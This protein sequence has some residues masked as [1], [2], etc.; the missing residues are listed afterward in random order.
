[1]SNS[2][3]LSARGSA[4]EPQ[5]RA[6]RRASV[7][8]SMTSS[9]RPVRSRT[10]STNSAPFSAARQAW[11]AMSR[12]RET[13]RA[14]IFSRQTSSAS[15]VRSIAGS[16]MRRECAHA[17]AEPHDAREGVDDAQHVGL[18]PGAL[19]GPRDQQ[20]AIIGAEIERGIDMVVA[21]LGR[22]AAGASRMFRRAVGARA[23]GIARSVDRTRASR[24]LRAAPRRRPG[25]RPNVPVFSTRLP[26]GLFPL[27][28]RAA[29]LCL[30][31]QLSWPIPGSVA[32][33]AG[34]PRSAFLEA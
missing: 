16:Q 30:E 32:R 9:S 21:T 7:S 18:A 8:R 22:E 24:R 19:L 15:S 2:N 1:M 33:P 6:A 34:M 5:P 25:P 28:R 14:L 13:P 3:M 26:T 12:A 29:G 10:R 20:P 23:G 11:V 31:R 17:L 27:R 4:S